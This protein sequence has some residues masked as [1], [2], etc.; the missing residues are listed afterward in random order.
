[1]NATKF[2]MQRDISGTNG[3]GIPFSLDGQ[4]TKLAANAE[5]HITV[6]DNYPNWMA[7][8]SYSPGAS[9]WV[10]GINTAVVPSTSFAANTARLNPA[11][12]YVKA[13]DTISFITADTNTP[14]ASVEFLVVSP[15][16]N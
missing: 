13:G 10:D 11:G 3:F 9:I 1:M 12:R 2:L 6:P 4:A 16:G 7:V 5:Q 14:W 15:Y 8:F